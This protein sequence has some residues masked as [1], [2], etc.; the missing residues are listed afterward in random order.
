MTV[1]RQPVINPIRFYKPSLEFNNADTFQNPDN[2]VS[3]GYDWENVN[4]IPYHLPIPKQWP[5]GQPGIDFMINTEGTA[6]SERFYAD[7]YDEDDAYYKS[8]YVDE[9]D[10]IDS[11][12]QF[13]VW[14]DGVSGSGIAEG[15]YT[16]KIF[17]L[18]DDELLLESEALSIADWFVDGIPFEIWN[19]ENDFG[20]V[21]DEG[22]RRYTARM[23]PPIRLYD[24]A[25]EFE[26]EQYR[27]DPG[28]LTTL[29]VIPQ[30]A[31][32]FDSLPIPL[33]VSEFIQLGFSCSELYLDRIKI[34]A[35]ETPESVPAE[36]TNIK[37][38][39][40]KATFVDFNQDYVREVVETEQEDQSIDWNTTDYVTGNIT[41]N[42]IVVNDP[43]IGSTRL[44][45]VSDSIS[46]DDGDL[47][48]VK[49]E[50]TDDAGDSDLPKYDFAQ[51]V[52]QLNEWGINWISFR[53]S[54]QI[55]SSGTFE[56]FHNQNQKA[57]YTAVI[58]VYK[59]V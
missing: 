16:V 24:P 4:P 56:L 34:N 55:A 44:G 18:D 50:I 47:L 17:A 46:W 10:P 36:G 26:K 45:V 48:L 37:T 39:S 20:I 38:L 59:I 58:D 28:I 14:L 3:T 41:A 7:L 42:S 13:R 5:D 57:V 27:D 12:Y 43:V 53:M 35:E 30:R 2:R 8:L 52:I 49:I 19:F 40:G 1:V 6:T 22:R 23:M 11:G 25:P 29:R 15:V 21:W 9:W 33:H 32:R 31:F 54:T 51:E